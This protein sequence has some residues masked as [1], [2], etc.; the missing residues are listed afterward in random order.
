MG[1]TGARA[2]QVVEHDPHTRRLVLR[3][4]GMD[5]R[6]VARHVGATLF[7]VLPLAA[8]LTVHGLADA[9]SWHLAWVVPVGVMLLASTVRRARPH[10]VELGFDGGSGRVWTVERG[11]LIWCLRKRAQTVSAGLALAFQGGLHTADS[12][13]LGVVVELSSSELTGPF[14]IAGVHRRDTLRALA[15]HAAALL[16][17]TVVVESDSVQRLRLFCAARGQRNDPAAQ[18][19]GTYRAAGPQTLRLEGAAG[20]ERV[21]TPPP[22]LSASGGRGEDASAELRETIEVDDQGRVTFHVPSPARSPLPRLMLVTYAAVVA[23][24]AVF[25]VSQPSTRPAALV[26][27]AQVLAS[28]GA[29]TLAVGLLVGGYRLGEWALMWASELRRACL[30]DPWL[31]P[32]STVSRPQR[33]TLDAASLTMVDRRGRA[34]GVP[35]DEVLLLTHDLGSD[36]V[37]IVVRVLSGG[38][39][40]HVTET[41]PV[42][43]NGAASFVARRV[44]YELA[45]RCAAPLRSLTRVA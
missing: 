15:S 36:W 41:C 4:G 35:V 30:G 31:A 13:H 22:P 38:R 33:I 2:L 29:I 26:V 44:A 24:V 12:D 40:W 14:A 27:T 19:A 23:F 16:G 34:Q 5:R 39:W 32:D 42:R 1:F 43:S 7:A 9:A 3:V 11:H 28:L 37:A 25:W 10:L 6:E 21:A 17:L 20:F 18:G 45:L 8:M